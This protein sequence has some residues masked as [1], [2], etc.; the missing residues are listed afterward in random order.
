M[1]RIKTGRI[2]PRRVNA[3]RLELEWVNPPYKQSCAIKMSHCHGGLLPGSCPR[4]W[5][6]CALN[7]SDW[8]MVEEIH[9]KY[10]EHGTSE[11]KAQGI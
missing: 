6:E 5:R 10:V 8:E 2:W 3:Q 7:G 9:R 11:K 4:G 1:E